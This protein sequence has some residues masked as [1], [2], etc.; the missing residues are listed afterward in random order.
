MRSQD[1]A[2]VGITT[3]GYRWS[4]DEPHAMQTE[5]SDHPVEKLQASHLN[6]NIKCD[7]YYSWT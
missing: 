7:L 6:M 4:R 3:G 2:C 1:L 5:L